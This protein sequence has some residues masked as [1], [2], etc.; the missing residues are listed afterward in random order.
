MPLSAPQK[1]YICQISVM[2]ALAI[3]LPPVST[4]PTST[5]QRAPKRS[6]NAPLT[7]LL[8][9]KSSSP[10]ETAAEM[11]ARLQPDSACSGSSITPGADR[12][13]A[14]AISTSAVTPTT[15]QP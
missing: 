3:R 15:T 4:S 2:N 8:R 13:P 11:A 7:G 9:P 1:R 6:I 14:D 12:T 10:V 5:S